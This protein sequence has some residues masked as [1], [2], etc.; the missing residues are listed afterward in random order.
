MPFDWATAVHARVVGIPPSAELSFGGWVFLNATG[1][2]NQTWIMA[3]PASLASN[4]PA[5]ALFVN[6]NNSFQCQGGKAS[7]AQ[8]T[9][10][11]HHVVCTVDPDTVL[12]HLYVDGV[13]AAG[14]SSFDMASTA[15]LFVGGIP[16]PWKNSRFFAGLTDELFLANRLLSQAEIQTLS[17][18]IN[19][20]TRS[21][22]KDFRV[23]E[24]D[25][26]TVVLY[27][28]NRQLLHLRLD[29]GH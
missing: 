24:P 23:E 27:N 14:P 26:N 4:T 10:A 16:P 8:K 12:Q 7:I 29:V 22:V 20:I 28:D 2:E 5:F 15:I 11:W 21:S 1:Y 13:E 3:A 6:G 9:A 17:G 18:G 19:G 25:N